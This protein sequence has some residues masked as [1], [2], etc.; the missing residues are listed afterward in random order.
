MNRIWL[1]LKHEYLRHITKKRF[2]L[3]ILSLPLFIVVII[4]VGMFSALI[5]TDFSPVGYVDN[6]GLLRNP[7]YQEEKESSIFN[8]PI[9]FLKFDDETIARNALI[10]GEIQAIYILNEDYMETGKGRIIANEF[11]GSEVTDQFLD[12]LRLN[13]LKSLD[14]DIIDRVIDGADVEIQSAED[15]R[16]TNNENF[17]T[18]MLPFISGLLFILAV[19]ISG[20]Y[21]LQAVV[22][23]KENRTMEIVITSVSPTQLMTGKII[24]NLG[25]GLTQLVIWILFGAIGIIFAT[26]TFPE[27][28]L[29]QID[30]K[31]LIIVLLTFIPAFVM[32]SALMA[33]LGATTTDVKEAQQVAGLFTLPIAM[34]F[35]FSNLLIE[36]PNSPFAIFLS[37]FPLT[38]PISLPLRVAFTNVPLWQTAITIVLLISIAIFSLWLAGKAFRLG[39]L[40][41]GKRLSFKEIFQNKSI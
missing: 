15:N 20:G 27:L 39:M 31:F 32:V 5:S 36:N 13:L 33:T 40:R 24:G 29:A 23:E 2:I 25:V 34:P 10:N 3:A 19:N 21:L 7:I 41:Y 11:P 6:S 30:S 8:K 22:E 12:L 35:W 1:V 16:S 14:P 9:K 4:G 18:L 26:N 37:I 38:A 17:L 28:K